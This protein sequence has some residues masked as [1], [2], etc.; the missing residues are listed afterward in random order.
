MTWPHGSSPRMR[1]KPMSKT[2]C[3]SAIG[4]I[5]AHAGKTPNGWLMCDGQRAHPRACGENFLI[6]SKNI[7][8]AGS[9]P[10]MRGKLYPGGAAYSRTGLIPAHAGKTQQIKDEIGGARAHPRACWENR[11]G[12]SGVPFRQGSSPRMRGKLDD[13][14]DLGY[15]SGLI[16]AHAGKTIWP[17]PVFLNNGAHPRACGENLR[18]GRL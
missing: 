6:V 10:R 16:P 13:V 1:G 17:M 4:L 5:P 8:P 15:L 11:E 9:S 18:I 12:L 14:A 2:C 3:A 7:L